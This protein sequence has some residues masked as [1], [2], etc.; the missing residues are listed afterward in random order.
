MS[1]TTGDL[2]GG[3]PKGFKPI[4]RTPPKVAVQPKATTPKKKG[5]K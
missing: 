3:V 4:K 1:T 5:G 2:G